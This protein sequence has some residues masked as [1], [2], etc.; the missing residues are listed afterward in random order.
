MTQTSDLYGAAQEYISATPKFTKK[1]SMENTGKFLAH[2]GNPAQ[3]CKILHVAGTNGKGSVCAYLATVLKKAGI[4]C[5]MFVSPHLVTMRE[6]FVVDGEMVSEEEF[7]DAFQMVK[8][9]LDNLPQDLQE[10][11]Y[12]PTF[13]EFLFFMAMVLFEKSGVE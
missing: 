8:R 7:V 9:H 5:G 4:R 6:R 2:L 11:A 3:N 12:H 1:N 10:I 13:F